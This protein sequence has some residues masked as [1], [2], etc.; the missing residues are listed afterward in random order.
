MNG[1]FVDKV[2]GGH[3]IDLEQL[4]GVGGWIAAR[5]IEV[6]FQPEVK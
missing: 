4:H 3:R 5:E 6:S 1:V 2:D